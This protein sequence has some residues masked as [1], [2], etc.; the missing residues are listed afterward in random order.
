MKKYFIKFDSCAG[1]LAIEKAMHTYIRDH[2]DR[3]LVSESAIENIVY[4]LRREIDAFLLLHR[5]A[6][7]IEVRTSHNSLTGGYF[8]TVGQMCIT[9]IKIER[10]I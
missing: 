2:Y 4:D 5:L 6:K 3:S 9:L 8:I 1:N 10:E 7:P